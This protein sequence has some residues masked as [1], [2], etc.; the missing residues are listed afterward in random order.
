M[1]IKVDKRKPL[2]AGLQYLDF[3]CQPHGEKRQNKGIDLGGQ[4]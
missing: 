1:L 4:C 2:K 3:A